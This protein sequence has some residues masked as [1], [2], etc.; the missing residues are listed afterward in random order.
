MASAGKMDRDLTNPHKGLSSDTDIV[1]A[2]GPM[3][4][5]MLTITEPLRG[6]PAPGGYD[7]EMLFVE[8]ARCGAPVMWEPGKATRIM[9]MAGIDALE[10][11]SSCLLVTDGCSLCSA[12]KEFTVQIFRVSAG[13]GASLP[14]RTGNA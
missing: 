12:E 8:C 11:D 1:T 10:L 14:P 9:N 3:R 5:S 4:E 2:G 7:P 6:V 13:S